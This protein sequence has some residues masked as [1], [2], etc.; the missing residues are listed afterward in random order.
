M[1]CRPDDLALVIGGPR[2]DW[3]KCVRCIRLVQA[4]ESVSSDRGPGKVLDNPQPMW[5]VDR[6]LTCKFS[7]AGIFAG[8][9][10]APYVWDKYLRP[11][12]PDELPVEERRTEVW[13]ASVD[14]PG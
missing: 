11:I 9:C 5:L 3:G 4:G 10:Q 13:S 1:N 6:S 2:A 14:A 12:R 8:A 7:Q